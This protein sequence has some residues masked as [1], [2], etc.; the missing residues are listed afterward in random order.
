V[1]VRHPTFVVPEFVSLL[2]KHQVALV[3][4]DTVAGPRLMDLSADFVYCRLHGSQELYVS[5]YDDEALDSWAE[6]VAAWACGREPAEAERVIPSA[7]PKQAQRDVFVYFDN[8]AKVRAP[9]DAQGL[10]ARVAKLLK[11]PG[12]A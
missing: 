11:G 10:Q 3:C 6:R 7:A 2:R 5:G 12:L 8:D 9:F 4:A 1:E